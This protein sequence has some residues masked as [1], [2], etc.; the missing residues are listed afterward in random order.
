MLTFMKFQTEE[1]VLKPVVTRDIYRMINKEPLGSQPVSIYP[2]WVEQWDGEDP[3]ISWLWIAQKGGQGA[4][5][6]SG[7]SY[8]RKEHCHKCSWRVIHKI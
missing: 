2:H 4:V 8:Q 6:V 3:G 1:G 5:D 7:S